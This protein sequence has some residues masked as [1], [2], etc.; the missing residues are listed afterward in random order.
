MDEFEKLASGNIEKNP[1]PQVR[2]TYDDTGG[3]NKAIQSGKNDNASGNSRIEATSEKY[4]TIQQIKDCLTRD[5]LLRYNEVSNKIEYCYTPDSRKGGDIN[6]YNEWNDGRFHSVLLDLQ[7]ECTGRVSKDMLR[8]ILA[9]DFVPSYNPF[10]LYFE[11]ISSL[12]IESDYIGMLADRVVTNSQEQFGK[13]F[14]IWFIAMVACLLD[15]RIE[16]QLA[17]ILKGKQG[18]GKTRFLRSLV[19]RDFWNYLYEGNIN[20]NNKEHERH[21]AEKMLLIMDEFDTQSDRKSEAFKSFITK[22]A[23]TIRR[24]YAIN[25]SNAPRIASFCGTT[26]K[27]SFLRD[28]TGSRRFIVADVTRFAEES[29]EFLDHAYAQAFQLWRSGE[30]FYLNAEDIEEVNAANMEY[31]E[32][33]VEQELLLEYF[34]PVRQGETP[35]YSLTASEITRAICRQTKISFNPRLAQK[36]GGILRRNGFKPRKTAGTQRYDLIDLREKK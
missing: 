24:P 7:K 23:V 8:T 32:V 29:F 13:Y 14:R 1:K 12:P 4:A 3:G 30:R 20:P 17:L 34:R 21:L 28:Y 22:Q 31:T 35:E 16:N 15:D 6:E 10:N 5:Y 33:N 2:T 19:P 26:N 18:I 27:D 11:Y 36:I 9:S 25:F